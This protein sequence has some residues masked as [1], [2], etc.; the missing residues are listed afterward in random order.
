MNPRNRLKSFFLCLAGALLLLFLVEGACSFFLA[1][2]KQRSS[3]VGMRYVQYDEDLGWTALP[4]F[5][6]P[7]LYGPGLDYQT[8]SKSFRNRRE[9]EG[10]PAP[11]KIRIVCSGDSFAQGHGVSNDEAWCAQLEKLNARIESVNLGQSG[12]G[13]DQAYL[14][15]L[16]QGVSV[17]HQVH[18]F[19]FIGD[20]VD[21]MGARKFLGIYDKPVLNLQKGMLAVENVPVPRTSLHERVIRENSRRVYDLKF[22]ELLRRILE[23]IRLESAA[24]ETKGNPVPDTWQLALAAMEDL[25][26]RSRKDNILLAAV[27][28]PTEEDLYKGTHDAFRQWLSKQLKARGILL[29]D[30]VDVFRNLKVEEARKFFKTHYSPQGHRYVAEHLEATLA[31]PF[32]DAQSQ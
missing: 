6:D 23:K 4:N 12:Y 20:D 14:R 2:W 17:P 9:F 28:L 16:K 15:Y 21:R 29:I 19:T 10:P 26:I 3:L 13:I 31:W 30:L 32:P 5:K 8:N 24:K 27:F 7:D 25:Q 1:V 18:L 11:G 22:I